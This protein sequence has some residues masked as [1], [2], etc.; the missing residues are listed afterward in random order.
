MGYVLVERGQIVG[1]ISTLY[2]YRRI[3]GKDVR[4]CNTAHWVV[5]EEHRA[6]SLRL[7]LAVMRQ[8]DLT[9]TNLTSTRTVSELMQKLGFK[10]LD[11]NVKLLFAFPTP[12]GLVN[13]RMSAIASGESEIVAALGTSDRQIYA[14]HARCECEHVVFREGDSYCYLVFTRK[15]RRKYGLRIPY[16]HV[17]YISNRDFFVRHLDH[18]KWYFLRHFGAW[19]LAVDERLVGETNELGLFSRSYSLGAPRYFRSPVLM[20]DQ[21]DNLYTELVLGI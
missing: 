14:D 15:R 17:H 6:D 19:L 13:G 11:R 18:I 9:I 1:F 4:F 3:G 5:R 8:R 2:S 21:I 12:A 16:C 7:F 20:A 10:L